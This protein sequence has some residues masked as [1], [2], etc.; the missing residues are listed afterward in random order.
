MKGRSVEIWFRTE[1]KPKFDAIISGQ[2]PAELA[3]AVFPTA[4]FSKFDKSE[5]DSVRPM[6]GNVWCVKQKRVGNIDQQVLAIGIRSGD[7]RC[8]PHTGGTFGS[9]FVC[10]RDGIDHPFLR[11]WLHGY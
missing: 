5:R 11:Q 7:H 3:M 10:Q 1:P 6:I 4:S 8:D 9:R 2:H